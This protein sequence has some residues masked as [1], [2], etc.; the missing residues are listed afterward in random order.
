MLTTKLPHK[1][2]LALWGILSALLL[3]LI[4]VAPVSA[5]EPVGPHLSPD[6][7]RFVPVQGPRQVFRGDLTVEGGEV[8]EENV[9]VYSG[10][11]DVVDGGRITGDLIV[12]AGDVEIGE[13]SAVDGNLTSYSGDIAVAGSVGGNL[14]AM[15]GDVELTS[16]ARVGG[17]I[18]VVSG[19]LDRNEGAV[20]GG[21]VVQGPT[22]RFPR[23]SAPD[24]PD[25]PDAPNF[26]GSFGRG[27]PDFFGRVM[28]LIGR[29]FAAALMTALVMLLVGGLFYLRPQI[30]ADTRRQLNE[31]L[32]LSAVVGVLA[33]LTVLFLAGL[34]AITICLLPL[35]LVPLLI[36]IAVNVVGWAVASQIVGERI[37]TIAKQEVQPAL[38]ILVGAF[39]LTG[40]S[41]LLWALGGCFQ[42]IASLLIFT[43]SSLG[44]GA[45]LVPWINR[46]R[47][48]GGAGGDESGVVPPTGPAP[49]GA[50][51]RGGQAGVAAYDAGD[52]G[53]AESEFAAD[54]VVEHD[55]AQPIDYMTAEEIN[56]TA[57]EE[58]QEPKPRR[59]RGKREAAAERAGADAG[60]E[61]TV[62]Q[63]VAAPVDYVTAQEVNTTDVV[64]EGDDFMQIK[65][66]GPT[67]AR[68]LKDAGYAT[69]AQLAA[70]SPEDVAAAIGWPVDR[71]HRSEVID[72]AKMLAQQ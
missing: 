27:G 53:A 15:S 5:E 68:R 32:A 14:A 9:L 71:V 18:S 55:V 69:F 62:E 49:S 13:G 20:V 35:A 25:A 3:A 41:T 70:A 45:V 48:S 11:V 47:G 58:A 51:E 2:P 46:R 7:S 31:Q 26:G 52:R 34:L 23:G 19:D 40:A 42:F 61:E 16:S 38:T 37:V 63:D 12:F 54:D 57:E 56:A 36:L 21:N 67:Y 65:G 6:R 72:Q 24:V 29:L 60:G 28:N 64:T 1:L 22:F 8:I 10:D 50:A 30:I 44:A 66:I 17:D 59:S 33:N 4:V 43:I 39:F